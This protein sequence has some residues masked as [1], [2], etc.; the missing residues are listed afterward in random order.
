MPDTYDPPTQ[1]IPENWLTKHPNLPLPELIRRANPPLRNFSRPISPPIVVDQ[2][3]ERASRDHSASRERNISKNR[4]SSESGTPVRTEPRERSRQRFTADQN[5]EPPMPPLSTEGT[6]S[7][8]AR[9]GE[10]Q[11][12][13]VTQMPRASDGEDAVGSLERRP[14]RNRK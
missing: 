5:N 11:R 9:T 7:L 6:G 8:V 1:G 4:P 12:S 2:H 13:T 10:H 14:S 3:E